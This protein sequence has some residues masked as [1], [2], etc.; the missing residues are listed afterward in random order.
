MR[1]IVHHVLASSAEL[2][3]PLDHLVDSLDQILLGDGLAPVS[4]GEHAS[5]GAH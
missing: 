4:D 5:L 1:S 2:L 3:V